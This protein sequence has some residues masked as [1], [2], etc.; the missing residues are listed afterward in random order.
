LPLLP[1]IRCRQH[2]RPAPAP[3]PDAGPRPGSGGPHPKS[4]HSGLPRCGLLAIPFYFAHFIMT[5][6]C[7]AAHTFF[8]I[9]SAYQHVA[10]IPPEP[11]HPP[12]PA[13][14][15]APPTIWTPRAFGANTSQALNCAFRAARLAAPQLHSWL[16]V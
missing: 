12:D 14:P 16:I 9:M 4:W 6:A 2:S 3:A 7:Q 15:L 10:N 1:H 13:A 8:I 5:A 11:P